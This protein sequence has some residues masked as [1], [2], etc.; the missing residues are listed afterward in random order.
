MPGKIRYDIDAYK[1]LM[2]LNSKSSSNYDKV[3]RKIHSIA[4]NPTLKGSVQVN[5][6]LEVKYKEKQE[7]WIEVLHRWRTLGLTQ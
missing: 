6:D 5:F 7:I 4:N 2:D 1:F 3:V